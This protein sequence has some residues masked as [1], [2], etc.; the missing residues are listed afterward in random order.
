MR[1]VL[2]PPTQTAEQAE[3][4]RLRQQVIAL[5]AALRVAQATFNAL[6]E[7]IRAL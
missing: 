1:D 5:K 7:E 6:A 2:P 3:N 4:E